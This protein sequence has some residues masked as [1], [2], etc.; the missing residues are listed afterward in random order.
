MTFALAHRGSDTAL[1]WNHPGWAGPVF[2][3]VD[4]VARLVENGVLAPGPVDL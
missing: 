1:G 4:V 2:K 3:A